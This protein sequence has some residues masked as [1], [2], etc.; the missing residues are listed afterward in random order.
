MRTLCYGVRH[1]DTNDYIVLL[2]GLSPRIAII[3]I[4]IS[5]RLSCMYRGDR[6]ITF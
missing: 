2:V 1:N 5:T 3:I 4:A 6:C